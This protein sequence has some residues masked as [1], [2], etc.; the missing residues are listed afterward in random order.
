[1]ETKCNDSDE[2][3]PEIIKKEVE[4]QTCEW[5]QIE[6]TRSEFL[7]HLDN[8][9][10]TNTIHQ[11]DVRR[12]QKYILNGK[13]YSIFEVEHVVRYQHQ[14][15]KTRYAII[16]LVCDEDQT[17]IRT[18]FFSNRRFVVDKNKHILLHEI[19]LHEKMISHL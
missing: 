6:F 3:N 14:N 4:L 9:R 5:C 10:S 7:K 13:L 18:A 11:L 2:S 8:C 15:R 1:M 16:R 12:N 17:I 19:L